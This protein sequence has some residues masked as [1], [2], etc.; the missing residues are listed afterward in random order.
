M[1][2]IYLTDGV[3]RVRTND[4]DVAAV[5]ERSGFRRCSQHEYQ[6]MGRRL[7]R[8]RRLPKL[9]VTEGAEEAENA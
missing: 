7:R 9:D 8:I 6:L 2:W 5:L 1:T 4:E 3:G